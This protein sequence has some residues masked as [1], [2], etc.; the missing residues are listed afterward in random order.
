MVQ[1]R[2]GRGGR[3]R[4]ECRMRDDVGVAVVETG[5]RVR[6]EGIGRRGRGRKVRGE[7]MVERERVVRSRGG[8]EGQQRW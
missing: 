7:V 3:E 2:G 8:R 1:G 6:G 5:R 4:D